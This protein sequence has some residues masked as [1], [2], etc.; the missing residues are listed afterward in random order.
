MRRADTTY[1]RHE[2]RPVGLIGEQIAD[3]RE[4]LAQGQSVPVTH[5]AIRRLRENRRT[6]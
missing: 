1:R 5:P 3:A 6:R 4:R 2:P